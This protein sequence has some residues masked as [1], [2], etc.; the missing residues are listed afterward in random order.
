[1]PDGR[2]NLLILKMPFLIM[3]EEKEKKASIWWLF[4]P[5]FLGVAGGWLAWKAHRDR[6]RELARIMLIVGIVF[7]AIIVLLYVWLFLG[8]RIA[9]V[10]L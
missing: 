4:V 1:M 9:L 5:V 3:G 6:E 2:T 8:V 7:T 10:H